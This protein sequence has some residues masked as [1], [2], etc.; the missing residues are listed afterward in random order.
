MPQDDEGTDK[1]LSPKTINTIEAFIKSILKYIK[2]FIEL[3]NP[4]WYADKIAFND[5]FSK[6]QENK[7]GSI[8]TDASG[9]RDCVPMYLS[10][11]EAF[12]RFVGNS[13][14]PTDYT[15]VDEWVKRIQQ[16]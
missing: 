1:V 9:R 14:H 3:R 15:R 6:L 5:V 11:P 16:W 7:V 12:I 2:L 4:E 8:I 10:T 13:L